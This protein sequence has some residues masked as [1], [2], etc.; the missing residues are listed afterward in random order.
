MANITITQNRLGRVVLELWGSL[1][2]TLENVEI[3]DQVYAEGTLLSRDPAT[4]NL[5]PYVPVA[6]DDEIVDVVVDYDDVPDL[7]AIDVAVLVPGSLVGDII[8]VVPLGV[9]DVGLTLPQGRCLV[10]GTVQ[11]RVA[12]VTAANINPASQ[13]FRFKLQHNSLPP[14]YVLPYEVTVADASTARVRVLSAGKVDQ[15]RLVIHNATPVAALHLHALMN[16]PIIP[17][18]TKQLA[19]EDN[20]L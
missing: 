14:E 6:L 7:E 15:D 2:T 18:A 4:G 5:I 16:R 20:E 13:T 12:N 9:W 17:I 8:T 1:L 10:A 3:T 11:V 19:A